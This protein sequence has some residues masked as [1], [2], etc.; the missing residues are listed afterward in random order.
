MRNLLIGIATTCIMT[1]ACT[2]KKTEQNP[3]FIEWNTP[4]GIPPFEMIQIT[5]YM[6][7][8]EA[9]IKQHTKE[10]DSIANQES[11]PTFKNTIEPLEYSGKLLS[12]VVFFG[13][14]IFFELK[15][16]D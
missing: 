12:K 7:A 8:L 1:T 11:A 14:H 15:C 13:Q 10:I 16:K 3:F 4:Y 2:E 5:D 9:G 6:P